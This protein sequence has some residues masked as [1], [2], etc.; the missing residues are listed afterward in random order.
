M[1]LNYLLENLVIASIL[2]LW[3]FWGADNPCNT[4]YSE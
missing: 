3:S 1:M 4:D 2:E